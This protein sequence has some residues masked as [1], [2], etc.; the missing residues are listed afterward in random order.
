MGRIEFNNPAISLPAD[1][2]MAGDN[3]GKNNH[4]F[5]HIE[6]AVWAKAR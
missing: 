5:S 1:R 3:R 6:S 2:F 4:G